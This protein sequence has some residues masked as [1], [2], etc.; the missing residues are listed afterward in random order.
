MT[1]APLLVGTL[2]LIGITA[3][4]QTTIT[5]TDGE[6]NAATYDTTGNDHTLTIATGSAIQSG[7]ISGTGSIDKTGAGSLTL[8]ATN[9][10]SGGTTVSAGTLTISPTGL[11]PGD[12]TNHGTLVFNRSDDYT[13]TGV[14]SGTGDLVNDGH[15]L[16]LSAAQTY[17]GS[18]SVKNGAAL[19]LATTVDQGLAATTT[20]DVE[21]G[22]V[23]DFSN[24]ALTLAGLTGS[25]TVYSFGGSAGHLTLDIASTNTFAGDLGTGATGFALT[26]TGAGTLILSGNNTYT[27]TTTV[28]AGTLQI[29]DGAVGGAAS[30]NIANNGTIVFNRS[31]DHSYH[32]VI[33]GSGGM[34]VDG[35]ILRLSAAQ[36]YTGDTTIKT[37]AILVLATTGDL[38]LA[39]TTTFEVESGGVFDFSNR[40][41]TLAGLTGSGTVYSFGGSAGHLTLDIASTNT[42]AGELGTGAT[43]FALT[44]TG[45]GTLILS[46]NNTYTGTTTISAGTLQIGDG[47]GTGTLGTGALVNNSAVVFN[48]TGDLTYAGDISGTGTLTNAASGTVTLNGS[49]TYT[50]DTT[51]SAGTLSFGSTDAFYGGT[52]DAATA[53]KVSVADGATIGLGIGSAS[54]FSATDVATIRSNTTLTGSGRIALDTTF[55]T[56]GNATWSDADFGSDDLNK[57]GTGTFTLDG[58][59]THTANTNVEGGTLAFAEVNAFYGGTV[60]ATNAAKISVADGASIAPALTGSSPFSSS[61]LN[62]IATNTT[63]ASGSSLS[64]DSTGATGGNVTLTHLNV[65]AID[66]KKIGPDSLTLDGITTHTGT[67]EVTNGTLVYAADTAFYGGTIDATNAGKLTV[68]AGAT[69]SFS[70]GGSGY[71][72]ASDLNTVANNATL[73]SGAFIG[74]DTTQIGSATF[75]QSGSYSLNK[76]GAGTLTLDAASTGTGALTVSA[77]TL[78]IGDITS[79]SLSAASITNHSELT[80][81]NS[82]ALNVSVTLD[83]TGNFTKSGPGELTVSTLTSTGNITVTAGNLISPTDIDDRAATISGATA[84]MTDTGAFTDV[85]RE[86]T[87]SLNITSGGS[88][89]LSSTSS[90]NY[91]TI[92][93]SAGSNGT[94]TVNGSDSNITSGGRLRVASSGTG[95]LDIESGGSASFNRTSDSFVGNSA[96]GVGTI[97]L[98]GSDSALTTGGRL[99]VGNAGTG[100]VTINA[101]ATVTAD[102]LQLAQDV[103]STGTLNLNSGGTLIVSDA[104]NTAL[105]SGSGTATF[106]FAGGTLKSNGSNAF[107]VT[108]NATLA[109][110]TTSIIDTNGQTGTFSGILS[111]TG[112]L[113][114]AGAGTL[115]LSGV[116]THTGTTTISAGTLALDATGTIA[117]NSGINLGTTGSTGTL[118]LTAKSAFSFGSAQTISGVGTIN[119]GSG[120]NLT[121]AGTFAPGN[122]TGIVN[123]TGNLLLDSSTITTLELAGSGG[124]AGT[125][126]DQFNVT[127]ALTLG[128]TLN[129]TS[130]G[131]FT[132]DP[133]DTFQL[134]TASSVGGTFAAINL[135]GL[136]SGITY[137]TAAFQST[138]LL[139]ISAVPEP[140]TYALLAG[141][142][143][144]GITIVRRRR[145]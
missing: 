4:A 77:G 17:T 25:G 34:T 51:I 85:G 19:V 102:R 123:V 103:G 5:F 6:T 23:F 39:A 95:V 140:G 38:G 88:F 86:A 114:K 108:S 115:T 134:F 46:G 18:T 125:D 78:E 136:G 33:S 37:D 133:G 109:D 29:G 144:L 79:G 42:F 73:D 36:T 63:F 30:D 43:G 75:N 11:V 54:G 27:G 35:H 111:G 110:G 76:T 7:A 15:I 56:D 28:S 104:T 57:I 80:F 45:A 119:I 64:L 84:S 118:D 9:I 2:L 87:G 59:T 132:L 49:N 21:S 31:D 44:K 50:G 69:A 74:L 26:K 92:G 96:T 131:G 24:R 22:G 10:H 145:M 40:A 20:V 65:G 72:S 97:T 100:T 1:T 12:I 55:A 90:L 47:G 127:G 137:D 128:G 143:I 129:L 112:N 16:R 116:N 135:S 8:S 89:V 142:A 52:V 66:L 13:F 122:S 126:F 68:R 121:L 130:L 94:V 48:R 105:E 83:G 70:L 60:D 139:T 120:Q 14:V 62:T 117:N 67:T 61:H 53:A 101:G 141:L 113:T 138:G 71:F 32:G 41:L 3:S 93:T 106:N 99:V 82:S 124:V 91:L 81:S 107:T 98:S 58:T